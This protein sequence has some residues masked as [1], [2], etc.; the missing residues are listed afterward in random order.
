MALLGLLAILALLYWYEDNRIR[1]FGGESGERWAFGVAMVL[2][3]AFSYAV[4]SE[5][6]VPSPTDVIQA[7]LGGLGQ[8]IFLP[9]MS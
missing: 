5:V 8:R 7:W 9:E 1:R 6:P 4:L 2:A 3:I